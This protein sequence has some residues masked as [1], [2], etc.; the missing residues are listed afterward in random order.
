MSHVRQPAVAGRFYP[1]AADVLATTVD[2]LL[3]TALQA[4]QPATRMKLRGLIVPHAGYEYSGPIAASAYALLAQPRAMSAAVV[5]L[6]PSHFEPLRDMA[7][8]PHDAWRTPL[9][10]VVLDAE[11]RRALVDGGA[12]SSETPHRAEHSIEVQL[13]F[14]QRCL[15]DVPVLPVA[16]GGDSPRDW[17]ELLAE[18]LPNDVLLVVSTDLSHYRDAVTARRLDARTAEAIEALD[19]DAIGPADACGVDALRVAMAWSRLRHHHVRR[20]DLRNSADTVGDPSRVV[21]YGAFAIIGS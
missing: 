2:G 4:G 15:P 16:V 14:F 19:V 6:G 20:L 17:A 12:S 11:V 1:G 9:G 10:E 13:P 21:G 3:G 7:A 18:V 8:A 5:I